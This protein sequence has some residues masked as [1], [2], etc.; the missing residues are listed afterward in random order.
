VTGSAQNGPMTETAL[1]YERALNEVQD[2]DIAGAT[3]DEWRA[4]AVRRMNAH[5]LQELAIIRLGLDR[6][7]SPDELDA[8]RVF[9]LAPFIKMASDQ[10]G[11]SG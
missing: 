1:A 6:R 10:G 4:E 11:A 7:L 8:W 3:E 2:F 5:Y 9:N